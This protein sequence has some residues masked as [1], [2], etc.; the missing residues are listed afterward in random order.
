MIVNCPVCG[1]PFES[2]QSAAMHLFK[3]ESD[4]DHDDVDDLDQAQLLVVR[5]N[6]GDDG[7]GR[8][9]GVD[10][11]AGPCDSCGAEMVPVSE[12]LDVVEQNVDG[13][14]DDDGFQDW[15]SDVEAKADLACPVC[16]G[17]KS[18]ETVVCA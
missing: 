18:N 10:V 2:I 9:G 4:D 17:T 7:D 8:D 6:Q 15:R 12:Y 1:C 16:S 3:S 14:G 11:D 13:A 5:H